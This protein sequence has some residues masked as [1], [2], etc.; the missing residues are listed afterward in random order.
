M[1][2]NRVCRQGKAILKQESWFL[3][4]ILRASYPGAPCLCHTYTNKQRYRQKSTE[5]QEKGTHNN[6]Y[7]QDHMERKTTIMQS[8]AQRIIYRSVSRKIM[9]SRML[10]LGGGRDPCVHHWSWGGACE[11]DPPRRTYHGRHT[12]PSCW[13]RRREKKHIKGFVSQIIVNSYRKAVE[14]F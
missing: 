4:L 9:R 14:W 3:S 10:F 8:A 5:T 7:H 1:T 11:P 13:K 6:H 12:S 2:T